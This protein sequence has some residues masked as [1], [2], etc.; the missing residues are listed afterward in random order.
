MVGWTE[1]QPYVNLYMA[2]CASYRNQPQLQQALETVVTRL[3]T[4]NSAEVMSGAQAGNI[5]DMMDMVLRCA[6]RTLYYG[7]IL[8]KAGA[9]QAVAPPKTT[10]RR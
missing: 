7:S 4:K 2:T 1:A 6:T 10:T 8:R 9:A 3:N 5:D